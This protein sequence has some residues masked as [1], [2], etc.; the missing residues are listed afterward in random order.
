M[1]KFNSY[2]VLRLPILHLSQSTVAPSSGWTNHTALD[3]V[4][5]VH[6]ILG[7]D[8]SGVTICNM[9]PDSSLPLWKCGI[10][11]LADFDYTAELVGDGFHLSRPASKFSM[12]ALM[13]ETSNIIIP[14]KS[15]L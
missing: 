5:M 13:L 8:S 15:I 7:P 10:E 11:K 2:S 14:T 4:I 3:L 9:Q 6:T 12:L 1:L